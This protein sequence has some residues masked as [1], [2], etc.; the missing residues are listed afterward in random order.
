MAWSPYRTYPHVDMA[1]TAIA[2]RTSRSHAHR[3]AAPSKIVSPARFPHRIAFAM[4]DDR[5]GERLYR[6]LGRLERE[7][8]CV[9]SFRQ[10]FR[11]RIRNAVWR[12]GLRHRV[13]R[14]RDRTA[15]LAHAIADAEGEF[16][17]GAVRADAA[18]AA[19]CSEA[20]PERPSCLRNAG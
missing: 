12:N 18:V 10:V 3:G 16:S 7:H 5:A 8:H 4:H 14:C 17:D 15:A 1:A 6:M 9:L 20:N 19:Q 2:R 13:A 11:W